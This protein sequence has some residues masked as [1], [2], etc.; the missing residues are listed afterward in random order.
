M[1]V[2]K[3][4]GVAQGKLRERWGYGVF[5]GV[6]RRSNEIMVCSQEGLKYVRSVRRVVP[7]KRWGIDNLGWIKWVPWHKYRDDEKA[8]GEVPEGVS[9]EERKQ[10]GKEEEEMRKGKEKEGVK[11]EGAGGKVYVETKEKVPRDFYIRKEDAEKHEYTK[12]CGGCSSW[13]RGLGRQPHTD[14]CRARFKDILKDV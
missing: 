5:V 13:N 7:E 12:G 10:R 11:Q 6:K 14:E 4:K 2:V 1:R 8:D 3:R 9:D